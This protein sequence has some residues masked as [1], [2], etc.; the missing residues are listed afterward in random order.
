MNIDKLTPAERRV[1]QTIRDFLLTASLDELKREEEISIERGDYFRAACVQELINETI[2][3]NKMSEAS[4][5]EEKKR[6][7]QVH[8]RALYARYHLVKMKSSYGEVYGVIT[9][10]S[11][12]ETKDREYIVYRL[13]SNLD[14]LSL[15]QAA[16]A[17]Q[18]LNHNIKRE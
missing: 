14:A 4:H 11:Q 1:R 5:E 10:E 15:E 6:K 18:A 7:R 9:F 13:V 3:D 12:C 2:K 8:E 16:N 17:V